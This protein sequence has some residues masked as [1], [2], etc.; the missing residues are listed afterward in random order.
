MSEL[1]FQII[2][3]LNYVTIIYGLR[4][5]LIQHNCDKRM[6]IAKITL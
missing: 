3:E 4:K 1:T 6:I 2:S 5:K